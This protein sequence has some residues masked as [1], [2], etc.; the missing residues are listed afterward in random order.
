MQFKTCTQNGSLFFQTIE[1]LYKV[2]L[3]QKPTHFKSK[4]K[5][6]NLY[7]PKSSYLPNIFLWC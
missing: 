2:K 7:A 1:K 5:L 4:Q 3:S 6:N